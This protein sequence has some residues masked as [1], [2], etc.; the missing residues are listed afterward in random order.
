[1][2]NRLK[3]V[4]I[5]LTFLLIAF[6]FGLHMGR[7]STSEG[8]QI[9]NYVSAAA[10]T[11]PSVSGTFPVNINTANQYELMT[12]PG[13][14]EVLALRI[15]AYREDNGGFRAP[16]ELLNVEGI[17]QIKLIAILDYITTGG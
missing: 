4:L 13:I 14:G 10:A 3:L 5:S 12:L 15:I 9:T 16:E 1:M 17:G 2:K 8:I 6:L 11:A 7:G